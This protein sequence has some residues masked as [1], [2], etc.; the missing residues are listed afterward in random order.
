MTGCKWNDTITVLIRK[1]IG[2]D[3]V[4]TLWVQNDQLQNLTVKLWVTTEQQA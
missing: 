4:P 3:D 1:L 2:D